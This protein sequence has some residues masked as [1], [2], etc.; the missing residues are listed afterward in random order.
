ME[1]EDKGAHTD[2]SNK[3]TVATDCLL[4]IDGTREEQTEVVSLNTPK[5]GPIRQ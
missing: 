4:P 3:E 5:H 2:G 1:G